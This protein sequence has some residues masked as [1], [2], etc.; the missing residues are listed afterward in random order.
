MRRTDN[1]VQRWLTPGTVRPVNE[2]TAPAI[3]QESTAIS[4]TTML[5]VD[6]NVHLSQVC[7]RVNPAS[8]SVH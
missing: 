5:T 8:K 3:V 2:Y 7:R 1:V 4:T 6:V